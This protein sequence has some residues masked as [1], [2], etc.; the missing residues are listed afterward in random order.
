MNSIP[1]VTREEGIVRSVQIY[2]CPRCKY[3]SG[4]NTEFLLFRGDV[5]YLNSDGWGGL[6]G[7]NLDLNLKL[8]R[9]MFMCKKC[10]CEVMEIKPE[11]VLTSY[12]REEEHSF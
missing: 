1:D 7:R 2:Q 8:C 3:E 11:H 4:D 10:A 9:E 5:C 6:I 12:K